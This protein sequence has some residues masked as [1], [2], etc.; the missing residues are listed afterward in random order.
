VRRLLT[1][2]QTGAPAV[3]RPAAGHDG[4]DAT[5][6]APHGKP[7]LDHK[8]KLNRKGDGPIGVACENDAG[9]ARPCQINMHAVRMDHLPPHSD[10]GKELR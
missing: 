10:N 9:T 5:V 6:S 1:R 7:K 4:S 2:C 3:P 8:G